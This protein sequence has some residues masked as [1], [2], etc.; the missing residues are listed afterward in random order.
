MKYYD[1]RFMEVARP[2]IEHEEFLKMKDIKHHNE[3][4]YDHVLDVAYKA[5]QMTYK[6]NLEWRSTIRGALL[7]D[8]FLYKFDKK[9]GLKIFHKAFKHALDHPI[10]ALQNAEKHFILNIKEKDIIKNHMFPIRIPKCKESWIVSFVDK[11]LAINEYW[12]NFRN[13]AFKR[14]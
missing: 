9:V 12:M 8:F 1:D 3:S 14:T 11:Y 10:T 7:H 4:V 6:R 2:I 5:Y 13:L